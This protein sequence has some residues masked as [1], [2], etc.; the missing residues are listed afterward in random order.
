MMRR[1]ASVLWLAMA[2]VLLSVS[3]LQAQT[4]G[5]IQGKVLDAQGQAIPGATVVATSPSLQGTQTQVSDGQ[6]EFRFLGLPPG[7]YTIKSEL[8]GFTAA[9]AANVRVQL[10]ST[11]TVS[12]SMQVA[13][14]TEAI[15]VTGTSSVVDTTSTATGVNV[16]SDLMSRIPLRRDIYA[17]AR[18]APGANEDAV[19]PNFYGSTGAENQY[20]I[21]SLNTTGIELGSEGKTLNADFIQEV[22]VKTGGLPAE[23]GRTTGGVLNVITKSGS[24]IFRG[25]GFAFGEGGA[26]QSDD[27]TRDERPETTT[28]VVDTAS[29]GDYGGELG[30]FIVKDK[31]W[32]FAAYDHVRERRDTTVIRDLSAPGSPAVDSVVPATINTDLF[33]GKLTY[34]AS[35][36]Q[37]LTATVMGDPRKREGNVFTIAG[38]ASTWDGERETGSTDAVGKYEGVF[39]SRFFVQAQVGQH[40]E[41]DNTTGQG[42]DIPLLIDMTVVPTAL[43][44]GFGFFQDQT[45]KRTVYKADVT[46]YLGGHSIKA[47]ADYEDI[48]AVNH[49]Y[50]SGGQRIYKFATSSGVVYYRHRFYLDDTVPDFS[51]NDESTWS[52]ALPLTT[53]PDTRNT[54]FYAQDSWAAGA[55]LTVNAG[56]R[57]EAQNVRDRNNAS[58]FT[59]H[60]N[61]APR[62]GVVWDVTR[63]NRSK[64]YA[65]W[66]RFFESVP[67]D[68][69]IRAF[70]GEITCFCY[71]FSPDPANI[72]QDP[73]APRARSLL[74]GSTEPVDPDLR[75]QYINEIIAGFEY[76]L[77]RDVVVGAKYTHRDLG[78]IIEDFLVISEGNYFIA[79]PGEGIG[80]EVTFYDYSTAPAPTARRDFDA[81]ELNARKR[82]SN[83]WQFL[84]SAVFSK[85]EGNYDGTYQASTGQL[86]P[87]INSAFDYADFLINADGKLSNDRKVQVKLDG[88]YEISHGALTG[89]NIGASTYWYSGLPLNAYGYSFLYQNWEYYMA[90]RGSVGRGPSEW[91]ASLNFK[92]PIRLG[93]QRLELQADLFNIFDR[94]KPYLLDERY[95]LAIDD[96]CAGIPESVCNGDNGI[97]PTGNNLIPAYTISDPRATATNPDYLSK[98]IGFTAPRSIRLG[99]RFSF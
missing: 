9:E 3:A 43:S 67:L 62:V 57:W 52:L 83:N 66:G 92:Y 81:F 65:N 60:D 48:S 89:L 24:N 58:A 23:Y 54:S 99:V 31:L 73:A 28:Q 98:A 68:I 32:F 49:N 17:V 10:D 95:N 76:D 4:T 50:N 5:R 77:G 90:P 47:G 71:N 22:E 6:G 7:V 97:L 11:S 2:T 13:G 21:D 25:S 82:F 91:E 96:V 20:I 85:L 15:T 59:L 45:F 55:G 1:G 16:G 74:G 87:N 88:S 35:G 94:Q 86:D 51:R 46:N 40:N 93:N 36:G 41:K 78:R 29:L 61:W 84:A 79:N 42:R 18:V 64:L 14:V 39:G 8:S 30:G 27:S 26:L 70:G 34:K 69:N 63:N 56:I 37:T 19:G 72:F 12:L 44:G 38:P 75:G 53:E 33:A 80:T